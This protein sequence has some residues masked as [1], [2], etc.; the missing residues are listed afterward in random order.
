MTGGAG[1]AEW[2]LPGGGTKLNPRRFYSEGGG[3]RGKS[4]VAAAVGGS[5]RLFGGIG[6]SY[7]GRR[8]TA[9][10]GRWWCATTAP[11]YDPH[12][13]AA[14]ATGAGGKARGTRGLSA[15]GDAPGALEL[16]SPRALE[17][18]GTGS[19]FRLRG[20]GEQGLWSPRACHSLSPPGRGGQRGRHCWGS[21]LLP[22]TDWFLAPPAAVRLKGR[23]RKWVC[24]F[25]KGFSPQGRRCVKR[26][27][28]E[29]FLFLCR[30]R[31][32]GR[33]RV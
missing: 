4:R 20:P 27:D 12:G 22:Y 21:L 13:E 17:P 19:P 33:K 6:Y 8:W 32:G 1:G 14:V 3:G 16:R 18:R 30:Y 31:T 25:E 9:R 29:A 23:R 11:G 28:L 5:C 15:P 7:S 26:E 24:V 2:R 10:A